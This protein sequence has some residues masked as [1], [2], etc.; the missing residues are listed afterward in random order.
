M[1]QQKIFVYGAGG[2]GKVVANILL[3]RKDTR[4]AGF[5]DDRSELKGSKVLGHPVV[6]DG[7]WLQQQ[8]ERTRITVALAVGE[9]WA[10]QRIARKC[11]AWGAELATLVHPAASVAKSAQLGLGT[12]V[13]AQAVINPCASIGIGVIVNTA[14]V[15]EHDAQIGDFAHV[16]PNSTIGGASRLGEFSQLGIGSVVIHC[17][18]IG[19]NTIVGAGA[20]VTRDI[21]DKVIAFGVPARIHRHLGTS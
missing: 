2:H 19:D 17:V 20:V 11:M 4:F 18:K 9:N 21:P 13:M 16:A 1:N 5:V 10:R 6:G 3:E 14:A 7:A 8:A 12:V 15:I